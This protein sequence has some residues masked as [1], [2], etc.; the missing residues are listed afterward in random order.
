[1]Q[2]SRW[3]AE[4]SYL[5]T[6]PSVTE[7]MFAGADVFSIA[8]WARG[9][10]QRFDTNLIVVLTAN[11][12]AARLVWSSPLLWL[13]SFA[14]ALLKVSGCVPL[15]LAPP[16]P[17]RTLNLA[18]LQLYSERRRAR[19]RHRRRAA[20]CG[21]RAGHLR[22]RRGPVPSCV[23]SL[24]VS[25]HTSLFKALTRPLAAASARRCSFPSSLAISHN[26]DSVSI[27]NYAVGGPV[28]SPTDSSHAV[29][30]EPS[31]G[32]DLLGRSLPPT[33]RA[34]TAGDTSS[35]VKPKARTATVSTSRLAYY[36]LRDPSASLTPS[37]PSSRTLC[38]S[39]RCTL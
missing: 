14:A 32:V 23:R 37:S 10:M 19:S 39:R 13:D 31:A 4:L 11:V 3:S 22:A 35:P 33:K 15:L 34:P 21:D 26:G 29:I 24:L 17:G 8:G 7:G 30:L 20:V 25:L 5:R 36:E 27:S 9:F 16:R 6:D 28:F 12:G 38:T 18:H 1:M 2:P